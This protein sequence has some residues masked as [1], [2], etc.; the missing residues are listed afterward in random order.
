MKI[1][2]LG[3]YGKSNVGDESYK[4]TFRMLFPHYDFTFVDVLRKQFVD[5][6]SKVKNKNIYGFSL[7][8]ENALSEDLSFFKHIYA[9]DCATLDFLK[10]RK[11]PC[12][13]C[14]DAALILQGDVQAGKHWIKKNFQYEKCDLYSNVITVVING[15]ITNDNVESL[16]RDT[17]TFIKFSYDVARIADE[18]PASFLFIPFGSIIP[19]DDRIPNAWVASKCK[20]WKKN[21]VA[22]NRM[23]FRDTL[24]VIS[25]S[26]LV[27]SSRLHSSIFS[28]ANG[29]P[30]IDITH[31]DKNKLFLNM[32]KK[33]ENS[34]SFWNFNAVALKEK[35][36][37]MLYL[38]KHNEHQEF[39]D[40][41][42]KKVNEIHFD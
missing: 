10:T 20:F 2:V 4:E 15:Y 42:W 13:F 19:C 32:I 31:H 6:L 25:A 22:F 41:I 29:V 7:G 33:L 18:T 9:R 40:L 26:N 16:A 36:H 3:F 38:P 27:I 24:N 1:L 21:F 39:R 11:I 35:I 34:I 30:F 14:P 17:L 12:S 37:K 28:F 23:T 5:Q 8:M